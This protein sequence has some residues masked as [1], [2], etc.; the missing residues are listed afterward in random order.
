LLHLASHQAALSWSILSHTSFFIRGA[1]SHFSL[2]LSQAEQLAPV[3]LKSIFK[4]VKSLHYS[5]SKHFDLFLVCV[6][7][8]KAD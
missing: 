2:T 7:L 5:Y 8:P 6:S 1:R 4:E 3:T